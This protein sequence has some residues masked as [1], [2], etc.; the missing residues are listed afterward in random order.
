MWGFARAEGRRIGG[1]FAG[2]FRGGTVVYALG[3]WVLIAGN[4]LFDGSVLDAPLDAV[5]VL[6]IAAVYLLITGTIVGAVVGLL[7]ACRAMVGAWAAVPVVAVPAAMGV[8]LW[9]GGEVLTVR[10]QAVEEAL[11]VAAAERDWL[12]QGAGKVAHA[13]PVL[14]A[15]L[16]PLLFLDLGAILLDPGVLAAVGL[17]LLAL[18]GL[19]LAGAAPAALVATTLVGAVYVR[20]VRQRWQVWSRPTASAGTL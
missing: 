17:L 5:M 15:V 18:A 7:T 2:G 11:G 4:M 8:A 3:L 1:A 16:L 9:L 14:L 10:A 19:V 12:V 6:V 20:R 13:G